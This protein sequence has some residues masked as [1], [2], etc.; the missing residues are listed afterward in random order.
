MSVYSSSGERSA[1][2]RMSLMLNRFD[3]AIDISPSWS[4]ISPGV[5]GSHHD[6][7]VLFELCQPDRL[8]AN[9][10]LGRHRRHS[11]PLLTRFLEEEETRDGPTVALTRIWSHSDPR[12][13]LHHIPSG[14]ASGALD[15]AGYPPST[16]ASHEQF[17][18]AP[19]SSIRCSPGSFDSLGSIHPAPRTDPRQPGL[20]EIA[21]RKRLCQLIAANFLAHG[22][23]S[24]T[25]DHTDYTCASYGGESSNTTTPAG[26][27]PQDTRKRGT[28]E[29][30]G[31]PDRASVDDPKRQKTRAASVSR[32]YACPFY[33]QDPDHPGFAAGGGFERCRLEGFKGG[34]VK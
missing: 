33:R 19:S 26:R 14:G 1:V 11:P 23:V 13:S 7:Y 4:S 32:L 9:R 27:S 10:R 3:Q 22:F 31:T 5:L 28:A 21:H 24:H 30:T 8:S 25:H 16:T 2:E 12:S 15:S 34:K 20:A 29:N 6:L 17:H 18:F